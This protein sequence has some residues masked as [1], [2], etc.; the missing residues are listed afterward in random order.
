MGSKIQDDII[1]IKKK[2]INMEKNMF[3]ESNSHK[4]Y[5]KDFATIASSIQNCSKNV[6]AFSLKF[7][8]PSEE[9]DK[10][11]L[12]KV[13]K[14]TEQLKEKHKILLKKYKNYKEKYKN[15]EEEDKISD[16]ESEK[17]VMKKQKLQNLSNT[18]SDKNKKIS[19][20]YKK[21]LLINEFSKEVNMLTSNQEE[22]LNDIETKVLDIET[23]TEG[24][25]HIIQQ[26][27]AEN[28]E[29][30]LKNSKII[31]YTL[32]TIIIVLYFLTTK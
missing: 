24:T 3:K 17:L 15:Y 2:L 25:Y 12:E 7:A 27:F 22:T 19:E 23:K 16:E 32:M 5:E 8:K 9:K 20:I 30:K 13:H 4:N 14:I 11:F 21:S 31:V 10:I 18:I 6:D 29:N 28:N 1:N 26:K